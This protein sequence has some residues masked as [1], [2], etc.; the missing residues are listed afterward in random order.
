MT[1]ES[2]DYLLLEYADAFPALIA[3]WKRT[4]HPPE[5][6]DGYAAMLE[7]AAARTSRYWLIDIR[8]QPLVTTENTLWMMN[9]FFPRMHARLGGSL[10]LAY[11]MGPHQLANVMSNSEIPLLSYFDSLPYRIERFTDEQAAMDW[12]LYC[13][14]GDIVVGRL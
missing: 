14:Q 5:L 12:L 1:P 4:A 8:F 11:L 13:H 3:R 10:Y 7:A 6:H 2:T 9:N